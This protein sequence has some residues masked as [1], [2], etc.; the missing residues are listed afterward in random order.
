MLYHS[1]THSP[2]II[3][4]RFVNINCQFSI[5]SCLL[6]FCSY[7][8]SILFHRLNCYLPNYFRTH[9]N[10]LKKKLILLD[11]QVDLGISKHQLVHCFWWFW[12]QNCFFLKRIRLYFSITSFGMTIRSRKNSQIINARNLLCEKQNLVMEVPGYR[13]Q[14]INLLSKS[15]HIETSPLICSANGRVSI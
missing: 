2:W 9:E 13:N 6:F 1:S 14:S 15:Y 12:R 4:H 3:L 8:I 5:L 11:L 7:S 10:L